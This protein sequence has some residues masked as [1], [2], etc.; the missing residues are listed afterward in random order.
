MAEWFVE[1]VGKM[2]RRV[3]MRREAWGKGAMESA[4]SNVLAVPHGDAARRE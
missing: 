1:A 4:R 3:H 2:R